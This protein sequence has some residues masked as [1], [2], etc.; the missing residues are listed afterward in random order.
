MEGS[1]IKA[2]LEWDTYYLTFL[3]RKASLR[4]GEM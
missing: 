1:T 3:G 4:N 2:S